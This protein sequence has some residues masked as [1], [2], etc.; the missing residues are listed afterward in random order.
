MATPRPQPLRPAR[1]PSPATM[2]QAAC[3]QVPEP[4]LYTRARPDTCKQGQQ[5]SLG[6]APDL[7]RG[8]REDPALEGAPTSRRVVPAP[9]VV[10][11]GPWS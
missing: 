1:G 3:S 9:A 7:G 11:A 5:V 6:Q 10:S 2:L 4:T 8:P